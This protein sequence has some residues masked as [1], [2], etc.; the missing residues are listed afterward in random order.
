MLIALRSFL[1]GS[2]R[3]EYSLPNSPTR[4]KSEVRGR[5][6]V[7]KNNKRGVGPVKHGTCRAKNA[8]N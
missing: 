8:D 2:F 4:G 5:K 7:N 6:E 1:L 3:G